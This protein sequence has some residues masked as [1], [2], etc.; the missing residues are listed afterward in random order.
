MNNFMWLVTGLSILGV[1][2]N[3]HKKRSCFIVWQITNVSW[4][5][6]DFSIDA[7]AQ[8]SLF[9]IYYC[10]SVWGFYAWKVKNEV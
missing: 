6:Y 8:G 9:F 1:M 5:I 4:C 2:L 10:L 3:I 7:Y